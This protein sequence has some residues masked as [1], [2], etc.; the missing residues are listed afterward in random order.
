MPNKHETKIDAMSS[1]YRRRKIECVKHR[2]ASSTGLFH[3][4][5]RPVSM[6]ELKEDIERGLEFFNAKRPEAS[7][8]Y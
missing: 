6:W 3:A 4:N 1:D 2:S 7:R 5:G 8:V